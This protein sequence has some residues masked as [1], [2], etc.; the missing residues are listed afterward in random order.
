MKTEE[1][2]KE[3][4]DSYMK[5]WTDK[6]ASPFSDNSSRAYWE[7][8]SNG[9]VDVKGYVWI[10]DKLNK[11][12]FK[13]GNIN[14]DFRIRTSHLV[15]LEGFPKRISGIFSTDFGYQSKFNYQ[16]CINYIQNIPL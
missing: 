10:K 2:R 6:I 3:I 7:L 15:S 8:N 13:F 5:R 12:P 11:L 14:G 16:D 4:I 1:L 9:E